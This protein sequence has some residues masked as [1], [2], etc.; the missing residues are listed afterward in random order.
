MSIE[1]FILIAMVIISISTI[2]YIPKDQ[3]RKALLSFL[4]FQATTWFASIVLVQT[5]SVIFPVREFTKA[6]KVV[7]TT[8]FFFYPI[9]FVWFIFLSPHKISVIY[10]ILHWI[11]FI[12]I[13]SWVAYFLGKY[14][15]LSEFIKGSSYLNIFN[16]YWLFSLQYLLC[17]LYIKWFFKKNLRGGI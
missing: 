9:I 14:T 13:S 8:E 17:F 5:G 15:N 2:L 12:S 4:V 6:T 16:T 10:K 11:L 7:F 1:R 3:S